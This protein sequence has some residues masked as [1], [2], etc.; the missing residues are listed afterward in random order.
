MTSDSDERSEAQRV[1]VNTPQAAG[2]G[3]MFA[4]GLNLADASVTAG[5]CSDRD[6]YQIRA[7]VTFY[8]VDLIA[9]PEAALDDAGLAIAERGQAARARLLRSVREW[10]ER[11]GAKAQACD[12]MHRWDSYGGC[13]YCG[14]RRGA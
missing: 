7:H 6:A 13:M 11:E 4:V 8:V 5:S 3:R 14:A 1:I 10:L 2:V 9:G 12:G